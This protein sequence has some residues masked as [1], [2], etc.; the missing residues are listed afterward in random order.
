MNTQLQAIYQ[1][2]ISL[3]DS[4]GIAWQGFDHEPILDYEADSRVASAMGWTA[5]PT[6]S[7][8]LRL[9]DGRYVIFLTHR[10]TRLDSKA[11]R[12]L[13]G[14]RPSICSNEEMVERVGCVP[15]AVCPFGLDK[16]IVLVVDKTLTDHAE[17]LWTPGLPEKTFIMA[18]AD[19]PRLVES[20]DNPVFWI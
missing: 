16:D 18:G 12:D 2:N 5:E 1:N 8:F 10:D 17:L 4:A 14:S 3:L 15:G 6:K 11:I 7:L 19:L 9:K 13:L 20:L